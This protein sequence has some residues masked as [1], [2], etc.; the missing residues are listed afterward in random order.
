[1]GLLD[2]LFDLGS[3]DIYTTERTSFDKAPFGWTGGK[4][5]SLRFIIPEIRKFLTR[6]WID[7][8]G[9]SGVVSWN[10]PDCDLMVYNDRYSG[11]VDFYRVLQNKKL[12]PELLFRL[13]TLTPPQS[14]EEWLVAR[15]TWCNEIDPVERAAKW[16]YMTR[17][18]VI[19]KGQS[20]ARQTNAPA[21][22]KF[23]PALNLFWPLHAKLQKFNLENLDWRV[24][25]KDFDSPDAVFY[26]DPPY[27]SSDQ[28]IYENKFTNDDLQRM[29]DLIANCKGTVFLSHYENAAIDS[30]TFWEEKL[31]WKVHMRGDVKAFTAENNREEKRDVNNIATECLWIKKHV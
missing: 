25:I 30:C 14:R 11:V 31:K 8:F 6:K 3:E 1:M 13:D 17:L 19:G 10:V 26:L 7:V 15:A 21:V 22:T 23:T 12:M 4:F 29:L 27:V 2:D 28:G 18:S 5:E 24:C 16:F 9:G 20:Y